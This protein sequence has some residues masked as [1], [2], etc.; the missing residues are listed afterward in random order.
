MPIKYTFENLREE[1][2]N[3]SRTFFKLDISGN[4][5]EK[6]NLGQS[7]ITVQQSKKDFSFK[8]ESS[9]SEIIENP[10]LINAK[11]SSKLKNQTLSTQNLFDSEEDP[12]YDLDE[13]PSNLNF[14]INEDKERK[15]NNIM[16]NMVLKTTRG[17]NSVY[18]FI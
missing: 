13:S 8:D 1:Q 9:D 5:S 11:E 7:S 16:N 3:K 2:K 18:W 15:I 17:N 6:E 4:L 12:F 14:K 10:N